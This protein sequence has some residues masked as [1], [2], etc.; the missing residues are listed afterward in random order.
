MVDVNIQLMGPFLKKG[1]NRV[2]LGTFK[3]AVWVVE[4]R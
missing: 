1:M 4:I 3:F 2:D